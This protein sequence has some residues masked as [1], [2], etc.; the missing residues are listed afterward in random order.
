MK[1]GPIVFNHSHTAQLLSVGKFFNW[2][3]NVSGPHSQP[4]SNRQSFRTHP[5]IIS[6]SN[7]LSHRRWKPNSGLGRSQHLPPPFSRYLPLAAPLGHIPK[8]CSHMTEALN[9]SGKKKFTKVHK[10]SYPNNSEFLCNFG[11][12]SKQPK[13]S[14][15]QSHYRVRL[16]LLLWCAVNK[17]PKL[18]RWKAEKNCEV[19]P[20]TSSARAAQM[21][22][23]H[24]LWRGAVGSGI[25]CDNCWYS[26]FGQ[27]INKLN[28][29]CM[30]ID[31][32]LHSASALLLMP[33][34]RWCLVSDDASPIR[35]SFASGGGI[36]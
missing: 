17:K 36:A 34:Q 8:L 1:T 23:V 6:R 29:W 9:H 25:M 5:T 22:Q 15:I 26:K 28:I 33:W 13:S 35:C 4:M 14:S 24:H 7:Q 18:K 21:W 16:L 10:F 11:W 27:C 20:T 2:A 32:L 19:K 30:V 12:P 31:S 3:Q